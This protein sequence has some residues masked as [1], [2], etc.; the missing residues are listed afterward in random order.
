MTALGLA[1]GQ[2]GDQVLVL[3]DP[4]A[5]TP[6]AAP[7]GPGSVLPTPS[8]EAESELA[9]RARF[10]GLPTSAQILSAL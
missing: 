5:E 3:A 4:V 9:G 1:A 10:Q 7:G 2:V 6:A 8:T